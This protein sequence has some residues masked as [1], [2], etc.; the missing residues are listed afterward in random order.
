MYHPW[1]VNLGGDMGISEMLT[2]LVSTGLSQA[3]IAREVGV[4]QPTIHR[5]MVDGS[6]ISY[7][8]GKK[9]EKLYVERV[10]PKAA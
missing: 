5:A 10:I 8:A 1:V 4:S 6:S 3:K 7:E 2:M 9:I